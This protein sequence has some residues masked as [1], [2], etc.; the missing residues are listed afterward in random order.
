MQH[1]N[2]NST[3]SKPATALSLL[4]KL[5][6]LPALFDLYTHLVQFHSL[7]SI[8]TAHCTHTMQHRLSSQNLDRSQN[9]KEHPSFHRMFDLSS[10]VFFACAV[11][12]QY[13]AHLFLTL[14]YQQ[15]FTDGPHYM[16]SQLVCFQ[17]PSANQTWVSRMLCHTPS[18]V[19]EP[20]LEH[21]M[22]LIS[23]A[24]YLC[25]YQHHPEPCLYHLYAVSKGSSS[26]T[27]LNYQVQSPM[28]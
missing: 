2:Y 27:R 14:Q 9:K 3:A 18:P 26:H 28:P 12:T 10:Y 13:L 23:S 11:L 24:A 22:T 1:C 17:N 15:F 21:S 5:F 6:R 25:R 7:A 16:L 20:L 19:L 4:V 8:G